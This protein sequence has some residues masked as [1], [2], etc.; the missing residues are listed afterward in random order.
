MPKNYDSHKQPVKD[1][2]ERAKKVE[3]TCKIGYM[4]NDEGL[5]ISRDPTDDR[6]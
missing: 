1:K 4:S 6:P 5:K 3:R 2:K